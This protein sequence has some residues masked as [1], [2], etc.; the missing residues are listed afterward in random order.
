MKM[1][2]INKIITIAIWII[3]VYLWITRGFWYIV[4]GVFALHLVEVFAKGIPVG[5]KAGKSKL[6]SIIMTLI[7]GFTW[8]LPIQKES[9]IAKK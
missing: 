6:Y 1:D 2:K 8:W 9:F 5:T 3:G 7:F 4:A